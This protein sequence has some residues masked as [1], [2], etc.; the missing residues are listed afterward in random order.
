MIIFRSDAKGLI[1]NKTQYIARKLRSRALKHFEINEHY[2]PAS[3]DQ[4]ETTQC[5]SNDD[6]GHSVLRGHLNFLFDL[7]WMS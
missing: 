1:L 4:P 7:E 2:S 5:T 6:S 3:N